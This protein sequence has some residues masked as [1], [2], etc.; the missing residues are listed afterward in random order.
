MP[1]R[2]FL[3][4]CVALLFGFALVVFRFFSI[5]LIGFFVVNFLSLALLFF[6]SVLFFSVYISSKD[7]LGV[8]MHCPVL[9][10]ATMLLTVGV[11]NEFPI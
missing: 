1:L 3:D 2:L 11:S 5:F 7:S 10:R 6:I 9:F 8:L 4:V